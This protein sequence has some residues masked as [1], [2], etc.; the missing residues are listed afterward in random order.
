MNHIF[1]FCN[2]GTL[3]HL[4]LQGLN[5]KK[6]NVNILFPEQVVFNNGIKKR[7]GAPVC[8]PIFGEMPR[9]DPCYENLKLSQH[10]LVRTSLCYKQG[11]ETNGKSAR[12]FRFEEPWRHEVKISGLV[13][14]DLRFVHELH[15]KFSDPQKDKGE[16]MPLSAAFH[17]YI[18]TNDEPYWLCYGKNFS[19]TNKQLIAGESLFVQGTG[20]PEDAFTLAFSNYTIHFFLGRMYKHFCVW[21]DDPNK[22]ICI[23]PFFGKKFD[24]PYFLENHE[25]CT[26]RCTIS[27][28]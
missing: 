23:E 4:N 7:G 5:P 3:T 10:G 18:A 12:F 2:N 19:L 20:N 6:A 28:T 8:C 24:E 22:Y 27:V 13:T 26:G 1:G 25:T 16:I 17:P 15:V 11:I 9:N 14:K 21:S